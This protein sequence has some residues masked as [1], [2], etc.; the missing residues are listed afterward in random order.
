[1]H[2]VRWGLC[3]LVMC[4]WAPHV[5]ECSAR[6]LQR[7]SGQLVRL[8]WAASSDAGMAC[9]KGSVEHALEQ[10]SSAG[11]CNRFQSR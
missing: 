9:N 6:R 4:V 11:A 10:T 3:M 1:M 7:S 8:V 5:G 2:V